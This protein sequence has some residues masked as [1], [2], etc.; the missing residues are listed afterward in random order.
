MFRLSNQIDA[1]KPKDDTDDEES[2]VET[3]GSRIFFY[4]DVSKDSVLSLNKQLRDLSVKLLNTANV[5]EIPIPPI[6]LHINSPGGSLLD[7][8]AAV[9]Y[10][11][12]C[13]V[14]VYSIIDGSAASAGTI[15]SVVANKRYMY[16]HSYMLIHQLSSG[17]IGK[18]EE[19]IDDFKN[20][21]TF[22]NA[23]TDIYKEHTKIPPKTLKE[24]LKRDIFFDA[25]TCLKYGLVDEIL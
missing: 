20:S 11:K 16:K 9:D 24:I 13:R 6:R 14:P 8:F 10:I 19:Q 17:L 7:A 12:H 4:S 3:S 15:M 1:T 2:T 25:Q 18:F 23:I 21:T 22:M 5:Y